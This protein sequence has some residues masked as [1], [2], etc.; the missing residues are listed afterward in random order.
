MTVRELSVEL[1]VSQRT[2]FRDIEALSGAGVP[3]YAI[4][5]PQGGVELLEGSFADLP[6]PGGWTGGVRPSG[7][8]VRATV[9]LSPHGR[10]LAA[11]LGGPGGLRVRKAAA[12]VDGREEWIEATVRIHSVDAALHEIL[13]L[14]AEVEV[15]GPPE[16]RALVHDEAKRIATLHGGDGPE[17]AR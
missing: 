9:R 13:A 17:T 3:V 15:L 5:G 1:E 14:G 10:R 4:R 7:R 11:L 6:L 16:L 2:V 8:V 12:R